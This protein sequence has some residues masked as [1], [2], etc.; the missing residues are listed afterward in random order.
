MP[1]APDYS[2]PDGWHDAD[3]DE[4]EAL[5]TL[6]PGEE[7]LYHSN[8]GREA[9]FERIFENCRPGRVDLR[10]RAQRV[11]QMINAW[12]VQMPFLV[13]AYLQ[14]KHE[15]AVNSDDAPG[16]WPVEVIGFEGA[17]SAHN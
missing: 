9:T 15:G 17:F 16:A 10:R 6:P 3:S 13:D 4:E 2:G 14:L 11:Q 1:K 5:R 8:E 7:G 12:N